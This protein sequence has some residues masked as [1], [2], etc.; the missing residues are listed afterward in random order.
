MSGIRRH[1]KILFKANKRISKT[2]KINKLLKIKIIK[3]QISNYIGKL[4][5]RKKELP[6]IFKNNKSQGLFSFLMAL[7]DK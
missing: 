1:E 4:K 7:N 5:K 3:V 2:I 6:L